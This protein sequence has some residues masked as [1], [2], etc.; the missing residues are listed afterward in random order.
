MTG[1]NVSSSFVGI[2]AT[3]VCAT[4]FTM[5]MRQAAAVGGVADLGPNHKVCYNTAS[6][7]N[8]NLVM[9]KANEQSFKAVPRDGLSSTLFAYYDG[10]CDAVIYDEVILQGDLKFRRQDLENG[11]ARNDL[12]K[13]KRIEKSGVVGDSLIWDPYAHAPHAMCPAPGVWSCAPCPC[14]VPR[15]PRPVPLPMAM[16]VHRYGFLVNSNYPN[17]EVVNRAVIQVATNAE[18]REDL[19][20]EYLASKEADA[21]GLDFIILLQWWAA[22]LIV[23]ALILLIVCGIIVYFKTVC[24]KACGDT[25]RTSRTTNAGFS[26]STR[27]LMAAKKLERGM[28]DIALQSANNLTHEMAFDMQDLHRTVHD[29]MQKV[30]QIVHAPM[31]DVQPMAQPTNI[32]E[33]HC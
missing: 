3:A 4:I 28:A 29:L 12:G 32:K 31:G 30:D 16:P 11:K 18:T 22:P 19:T 8:T 10:Q 1:I 13:K 25:E 5:D 9:A 14:P 15:A 24:K 6:S 2:L 26:R 27:Q 17:Y 20:T 23:T 7:F 21:G 33:V